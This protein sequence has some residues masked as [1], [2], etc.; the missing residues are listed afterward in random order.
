MTMIRNIIVAFSMYSRIP[1]PIFN[2][3]EKDTKYAISFIPLIGIVIGIIEF[4][5]LLFEQELGIPTFVRTF[6]WAGIPLLITGGFHVDGFMD[7]MDAWKSYKSKEEKLSILKDPHIGAFSVI[8]LV[9]YGC[10]YLAFAYLLIDSD[11]YWCIACACIG[12][13]LVRAIGGYLSIVF[14]HARQDGMLHTETKNTNLISKLILLTFIALLL[15]ATIYIDLSVA[16]LEVVFLVVFMYFYR[17]K[18]YKE[19]DGITGD[20]I[21]Y[22]ITM[23]EL[24]V[25]IIAAVCALVGQ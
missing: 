16:A 18:C 21:G 14:H 4:C 15:V 19:F 5:L 25:M 2:W 7:T 20:T 17:A 6:L 22:F 24:I 12:F 9:M 1:M 10:F 8:S 11:N 13:A 23:G 3:K